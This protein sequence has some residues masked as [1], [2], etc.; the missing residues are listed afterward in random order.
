[1]DEPIRE[2]LAIRKDGSTF[3]INIYS[4]LIQKDGVVAGVRGI[5]IDIT[6]K[7]EA[8]EKVR[9]EQQFIKT[10]LETSPAFF[11][12]IGDDGTILK[13]NT[14]LLEAVEYREEDLIGKDYLTALV[15]EEEHE[16]LSDIFFQIMNSEKATTN[17]N[18]IINRTGKKILVEWHGRR[19][20]SGERAPGFI[21]GV[22]IDITGRIQA[23]DSLREA[24]RK[25]NLLSS[26]TRHDI[27]NK[28]MTIKG[29]LAVAGEKESDEEL[30]DYLEQLRNAADA[31]ERQIEFT[32]QYDQIAVNEPEWISLFD[33][34]EEIDDSL[35]PI[36]AVCDPVLIYAE[37]MIG[38][39][40]TNLYDNA[41]RH[42]EGATGITIR[43]QETDAGLLISWEDDGPGIPY[44]QKEKVFESGFGRHTGFGL[45]LVSE[46]LDITGITISETG[47]PGEGARFDIQ[48]PK[49]GFCIQPSMEER[50]SD[51][52]GEHS[53]S[54]Q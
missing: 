19:A 4:S 53:F 12:A 26:I 46:I 24:N 11:V 13:M 5:I 7:K 44:D 35:L 38:K 17:Q 14:A 52:G 28:I 18:H 31:I 51:Q 21:V 41:L 3:P 39:V 32:R 42:A 22:G 9:T 40:F 43:C 30:A 27:L 15:P 34:L 49:G 20:S 10:L 29:Y 2:Y 25:L 50:D 54:G 36:T 16:Y 23:E 48:V 8:E 47:V 33:L 45:F 1:L 37:P 6:D